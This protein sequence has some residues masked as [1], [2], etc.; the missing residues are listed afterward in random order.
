MTGH[1][2][3]FI[4]DI[5]MGGVLP[6]IT[7]GLSQNGFVIK[8]SPKVPLY[9]DDVIVFQGDSITD[10]GRDRS[11]TSPNNNQGLG[12]GYVFIV[13]SEL[14]QKS[15]QKSLS[16]YNRAE[17]G[18][19]ISQMVHR[20]EKDCLVLKPTVISILI[21]INDYWIK[22]ANGQKGDPA[23]YRDEL[24]MLLSNT[25]KMYPR[26]RFI[27]G[28][29]YAIPGVGKVDTSWLSGLQDYQQAARELAES[30]QAAFIPYQDIYHHAL[31]QAP[32]SYWTADGVHPSVSGDALMA[33]S[34]KNVFS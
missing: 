22:I 16:F 2:R 8:G 14:L 28:E 1:R 25:R 23:A 11:I 15:A 33:A 21:G 32:P 13:A 12:I 4:R 7:P 17:S 18:N 20:W 26:V 27:I 3:K 24:K 29:P 9:E 5:T 31:K 10:M 6:C 19:T 34:V 30:F